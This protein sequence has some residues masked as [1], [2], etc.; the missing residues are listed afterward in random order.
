MSNEYITVP[1]TGRRPVRILEADWPVVAEAKWPR[2]PLAFQADRKR[3]LRVRVHADGRAIV[4][5]EYETRWQGERSYAGGE[6]VDAGADI[7][8][9]IQRVAR[10][11]GMEDL[12]EDCIG[13]LPPVTI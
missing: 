12:A 7:P 13:K 2:G 5:G 10:E 3:R 8:Q 6:C 11:M 4:T 1:L 9:A